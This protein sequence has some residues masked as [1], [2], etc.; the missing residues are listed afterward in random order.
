MEEQMSSWVKEFKDFVNRGNLVELAVAFVLGLAFSAA[1][2]SLVEDVFTPIIAAIF[3]QPDFRSL[4]M[5]IGD[6]AIL[7]G[8]FLNAVINFVIIAFVLFLV[9]KAYNRFK[10]DQGDDPAGPTEVELLTEIRDA[11]NR[12]G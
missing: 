8:R 9:V 3:G 6:S 4:S 11:L 12:R 7:Y 2:A 1:V 5:D 10:A